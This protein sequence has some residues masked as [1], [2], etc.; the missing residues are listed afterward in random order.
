MFG[1][2]ILALLRSRIDA[3]GLFLWVLF[4]A[5]CAPLGPQHSAVWRGL[6]ALARQ[7]DLRSHAVVE[8]SEPIAGPGFCD[9]PVPFSGWKTLFPAGRSS[10][11]GLVLLTA[12]ALN[13]RRAGRMHS[14][15]VFPVRRSSTCRRSGFV[16]PGPVYNEFIW[17]GYLLYAWP[18]VPVFIDGQTDFYGEAV[19]P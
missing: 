16:P 2:I 8:R 4:A 10:L 11:V 14:P 9:G 1:T 13:R 15:E 7:V 18:E 19:D 12:G 3:L 5:F 6:H 17:G